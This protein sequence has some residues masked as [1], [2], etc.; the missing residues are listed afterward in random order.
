MGM[1]FSCAES[2]RAPVTV[3]R[4]GFAL[5]RSVWLPGNESLDL[6]ALVAQHLLKPL[7]DDGINDFLGLLSVVDVREI[8]IR[9]F[10]LQK[11]MGR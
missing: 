5:L 11:D 3:V 1:L 8:P 9:L 10:K 7:L 6:L 4:M 2:A